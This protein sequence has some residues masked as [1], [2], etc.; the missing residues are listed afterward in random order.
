MSINE[1]IRARRRALGMTQEQLASRLFVDRS[2]ISRWESGKNRPSDEQLEKLLEILGIV[3]PAETVSD[4][5]NQE[6]YV[7]LPMLGCVLCVILG[8]FLNPLGILFAGTAFACSVKKQMPLWIRAFC[9]VFVLITVDEL[10][11]LYGISVP[12]LFH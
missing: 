3:S 5:T 8:F 6:G 9:L 7:T 4:Q 10:L 2:L 11:F 12:K 1:Q